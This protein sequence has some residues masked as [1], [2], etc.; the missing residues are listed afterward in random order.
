MYTILGSKCFH[1]DLC[2]KKA[3]SE[4]FMFLYQLY[5]IKYEASLSLTDFK[6]K[7]YEGQMNWLDTVFCLIEAH[8][9]RWRHRYP[10]S[11][12]IHCV[13]QE[14]LCGTGHLLSRIW[15]SRSKSYMELYVNILWAQ[16]TLSERMDF[17]QNWHDFSPWRV[18]RSYGVIMTNLCQQL[19]VYIQKHTN[20]QAPAP[21]FLF[22]C[23]L[24][25]RQYFP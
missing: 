11:T 7:F 25:S 22:V 14:P 10:I 18:W 13:L 4:H 16:Y 24:H 6:H 20:A 12:N 15:Y 21:A 1:A 5:L 2:A 3:S 17:H 19:L 9:L 8:S 23:I